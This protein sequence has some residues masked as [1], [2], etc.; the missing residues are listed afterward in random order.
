M[1]K[2]DFNKEIEKIYK[3]EK[4]LSFSALKAFLQSPKHFFRYKTDTDKD[5]KSMKEGTMFHM[6]VLEPDKF[7]DTYWV[8]DDAE[9]CKSI[10]GSKPRG[11]KI[12]K[13]WLE[14]MIAKNEGKEMISKDEYDLYLKMGEYLNECSATSWIMKGLI[15]KE[16]DFEF[17]HDNFKIRG[18]IDGEGEDYLMDLKKVADASYNK[19]KWTIRDMRYDM[20]AAIYSYAARKKK[21]YLV[22]ID[23]AINV[24]VVKVSEDTLQT[25]FTAFESSLSEF[26]RCIEEDA[27]YSSYEFFNNGYIEI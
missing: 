19:V 14:D 17:D 1:E 13:L 23:K 15:H 26:Q 11:T 24:T 16:K 10:G 21:Y 9:K 7:K 25:G 22:F 3:R 18:K 4:A 12:Y 20:Q 8:L 5:T 27:F 2:T 6:A